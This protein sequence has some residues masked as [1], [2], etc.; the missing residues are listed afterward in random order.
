MKEKKFTFGGKIKI[1][2]KAWGT[3]GSASKQNNNAEV[4]DM[5][6]Q[7]GAVPPSPQPGTS[8]DGRPNQRRATSP[9]LP[10]RHRHKPAAK[11]PPSEPT[12]AATPPS[13]PQKNR[14]RQ[15]GG[16]AGQTEGD[17]VDFIYDYATQNSKNDDVEGG[18]GASPGQRK[19]RNGARYSFGDTDAPPLPEKKIYAR[20]R[21]R[22]HTH[23]H[24]VRKQKNGPSKPHPKSQLVVD[25]IDATGEEVSMLSAVSASEL[26]SRGND[27]DTIL[28]DSARPK[29]QT[30]VKPHRERARA[31][32]HG[33]RKQKSGEKQSKSKG[34]EQTERETKQFPKTH[35]GENGNGHRPDYE[36]RKPSPARKDRTEYDE[37]REGNGV[38][39]QV[40]S[41]SV[42]DILTQPYDSLPARNHSPSG[43]DSSSM[44]TSPTEDASSPDA[45]K[46]R[47]DNSRLRSELAEARRLNDRDAK[48]ID[49][50]EEELKRLRLR[51][52]EDAKTLEAM[53]Q[54]VEANLKRTTERAV[55]AE[56]T[57]T[58]LKK[59][60]KALKSENSTTLSE[61]KKFKEGK[62]V[63]ELKERAH[64]ASLKLAGAAKDAESNL[65]QLMAGV[66]IL[67]LMAETLACFDKLSEHT[68]DIKSGRKG[69]GTAL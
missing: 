58:T 37:V 67:K 57:I 15:Q 69:Y 65:K 50:M 28:D 43:G 49:T 11:N 3:S 16:R 39:G 52:A 48:R 20:E 60:I 38:G 1:L 23:G 45:L 5:G 33:H 4:E 62:D 55:S 22:A 10:S 51:E 64:T 14:R 18:K 31:H 53:V 21:A 2:K 40:K 6:N 13:T 24:A 42:P 9:G 27:S 29:A 19:V 17:F 68:G 66:D 12:E 35:S 61:N 44:S 36:Q 56:N 32:S 46:L 54:H 59:E 8:V 41:H 47:H 25:Y 26:H 34:L 7:H 63:L 30:D